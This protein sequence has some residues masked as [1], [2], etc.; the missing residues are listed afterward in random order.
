MQ[1]PHVVTR[2]GDVTVASNVKV[3][4]HGRE[5]QMNGQETEQFPSIGASPCAHLVEGVGQQNLVLLTTI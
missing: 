5:E 1:C 3:A 4:F 2:D